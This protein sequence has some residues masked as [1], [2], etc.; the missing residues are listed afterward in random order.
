MVTMTEFLVFLATDL[1]AGFSP[2]KLSRLR[3]IFKTV[4][5]SKSL[6]DFAHRVVTYLIFC[7]IE[8]E[9]V[10]NNFSKPLT[11]KNWK[12]N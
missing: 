2:P 10:D 4:V 5:L 8:N 9:T 12:K 6:S 1:N 3:K 11:R 7:V